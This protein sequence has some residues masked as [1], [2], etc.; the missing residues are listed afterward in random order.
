MF[1]YEIIVDHGETAN[2]C[3]ILPL[4]YR[5]DFHLYRGSYHGRLTADVLLH[6][7]GEPLELLRERL[8]APASLALIDCVWRRL[9]P[10]IQGLEAPL[11]ILASIPSDFVTAYPR[12]S[13]FDFD[14]EGG[15][16][17]IEALFVGAALL[18]QWDLSLLREYFFAEEFL[19]RNSKSFEKHGIEARWH[20]AIYQPL[21]PKNARTR[22]WGRGRGMEPAP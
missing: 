5:A 4:D 17:T 22:R 2:K 7:K 6:P 19:Q 21:R 13:K 20:G 1:R 12:V 10:I 18:G 15:L 16:A 9:D 8:I 11:P 14:P 3:T